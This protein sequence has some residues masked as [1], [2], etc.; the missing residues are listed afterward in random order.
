MPQDTPENEIPEPSGPRR[1]APRYYAGETY[2]G[3]HKRGMFIPRRMQHGD[4]TRYANGALPGIRNKPARRIIRK[5]F[6]ASFRPVE[7]HL[8]LLRAMKVQAVDM[9]K[10]QP[11]WKGKGTRAAKRILALELAL[12]QPVYAPPYK[13]L[14]AART[15]A[16]KQK[17]AK[18]KA[19][20]KMLAGIVTP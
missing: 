12:H 2:G 18:A 17:R 1:R 20:K 7:H 15:E 5:A 11:M 6:S 3:R 16:R 9:T 14:R 19:N 4:V 13:E 10:N 8:K